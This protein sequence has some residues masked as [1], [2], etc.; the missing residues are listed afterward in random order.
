MTKKSKGRRL[1]EQVGSVPVEKQD[2]ANLGRKAGSKVPPAIR[3]AK[4]RKKK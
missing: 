1:D 4:R 2:L 3:K